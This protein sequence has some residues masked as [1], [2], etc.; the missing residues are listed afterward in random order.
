MNVYSEFRFAEELEQWKQS[1]KSI[2]EFCRV[3]HISYHAFMYWKKKMTMMSG[4]GGF[5][6]IKPSSVPTGVVCE[7]ISGSGRRVVFHRMPD[8]ELL[9]ALLD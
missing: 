5:I 4:S 7:L 1:G 9:R 6:Q 3:N 2:A 8:V